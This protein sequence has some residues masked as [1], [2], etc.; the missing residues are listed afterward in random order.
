MGAVRGED[1]YGRPV[2][3]PHHQRL[4]A[5]RQGCR[6]MLIELLPGRYRSPNVIRS[7]CCWV[8]ICTRDHGEQLSGAQVAPDAPGAVTAANTRQLAD[9]ALFRFE[10]GRTFGDTRNLVA[11]AREV[12]NARSPVHPHLHSSSLIARF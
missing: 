8:H 12:C 9:F 6:K 11:V 7:F 2:E 10:P 1:R 5:F 4:R 3:M